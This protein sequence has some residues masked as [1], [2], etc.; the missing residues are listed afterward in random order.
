MDF[1]GGGTGLDQFARLRTARIDADWKRTSVMA[2]FD[3]PLIA[4]RDPDSLAQMGVSPLTAAG[5]LWL[6]QPQVRVEHRLKFGENSGLRAQAALYQTQEAGTGLNTDTLTP[7]RP[8]YQ[9]RFE[10]WAEHGSRRVEIAPGFHVSSTRAFGVSI[11]SRIFAVDWLIRPVP[12]IDLTGT[13]FNGEN[14]S[15]LGST[16]Q[17]VVLNR[18]RQPVAVPAK[19]GWAQLKLRL[20]SRLQFNAFGGEQDD[21][22]SVLDRS[23]NAVLKN[24]SFGANFMYR[25]ST[26]VITG[27]EAS[28]VRTHYAQSGI[29]LNPHY[30]LAIAYQF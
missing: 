2:G 6:W 16:R 30:D 11:P 27:I 13:F 12:K 24:Q 9:G 22:N 3:K 25:V 28:Q 18:S 5:N 7:A 21:D 29:R 15:V 20:T 23:T 10:L 17:G 1:F 4:Q 26:N 14:V 19:G 8:G